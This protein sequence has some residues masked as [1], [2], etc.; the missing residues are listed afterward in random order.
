MEKFNNQGLNAINNKVCA[1]LA[2]DD[3]DDEE[4]IPNIKSKQV[5]N[6]DY[7]KEYIDYKSSLKKVYNIEELT[8]DEEKTVLFLLNKYSEDILKE[9]ESIPAKVINI[10]ARR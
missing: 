2:L 5:Y 7:T 3:F 9:T 1:P 10:S 8:E 6:R 4:P